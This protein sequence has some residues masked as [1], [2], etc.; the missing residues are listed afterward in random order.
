[1]KLYVLNTTPQ[2]I[3]F[4]FRVPE[5]KGTRFVGIGPGQQELVYDGMQ[6]EVRSI[7]DQHTRYGLIEDTDVRSHRRGY[8][9]MIFATDRPVNIEHAKLAERQNHTALVER[10]DDLRRASAISAAEVL[11]KRVENSGFSPSLVQ[12]TMVGT[13]G[14]DDRG[15]PVVVNEEIT[16]SAKGSRSKK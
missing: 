12:D 4:T 3:N 9:G 10:G 6:S 2:R 14:E 7:I 15:D 1:M 5:Q 16:V 8:V 11:S 13:R